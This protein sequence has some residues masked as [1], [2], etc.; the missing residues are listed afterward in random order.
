MPLLTTRAGVFGGSGGGGFTPTSTESSNFLTRATGIT[1]NTDKT[2]Y[3]ALITGLVTDS[4]FSKLDVLYIFAAPT[5]ATAL[6]NLVQSS[7]SATEHGTATSWSAAGG[8]TGDGSSFYLDTGAAPAPGGAPWAG[9]YQQ[10]S[11]SIGVYALNNVTRAAQDPAFGAND[12]GLVGMYLNYYNTTTYWDINTSALSHGVANTSTTG[13]WVVTRTGASACALYKN[14][15][16]TAFDS[17]SVTSFALPRDNII[18]FANAAGS[19]P[20]ILQMSAAFIGSGLTN[21]QQA[22]LAARIN[23]FMTAYGINVY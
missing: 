8:F 11:A 12:N 18:L 6:L 3:D 19:S 1:S 17:S 15:S 4:L 23:T 20:S 10:D 13:Q 22:A 2:R 9:Q 7:F 16:T 14:G 21:T 5:R